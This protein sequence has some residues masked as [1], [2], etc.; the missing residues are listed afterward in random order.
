MDTGVPREQGKA[1]TLLFPKS[2]TRSH[3]I[4]TGLLGNSTDRC[5]LDKHGHWGSTRARRSTDFIIPHILSF[6][7]YLGCL[8]HTS[9]K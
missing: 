5:L 7:D 2:W 4:R 3:G 8:V 9:P 6:M 1:Q